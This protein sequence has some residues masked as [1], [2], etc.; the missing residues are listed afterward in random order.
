[1]KRLILTASIVI[2]A[3]LVSSLS[4]R[5]DEPKMYHYGFIL[6]CG[7]VYR[8]YDHPLSG[9]ELA[10][11]TDKLEDEV[12]GGLTPGETEIH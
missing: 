1:M 12:C 7:T 2:A 6:S 3:M 5:G 11:L 9:D 8:S 4:V 10:D